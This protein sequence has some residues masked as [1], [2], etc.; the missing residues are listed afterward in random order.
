MIDWLPEKSKM[1]S[2][3]YGMFGIFISTSIMFFFIVAA[4]LPRNSPFIAKWKKHYKLGCG[5]EM[6]LTG[7]LHY[8]ALAGCGYSTAFTFSFIGILYR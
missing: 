1:A 5:K 4:K 2:V 7:A 3:A 8:A 6:E